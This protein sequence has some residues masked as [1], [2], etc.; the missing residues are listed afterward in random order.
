MNPLAKKT[1]YSNF[2]TEFIKEKHRENELY[3]ST[4]GQSTV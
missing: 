4:V 1:I 2:L 3:K